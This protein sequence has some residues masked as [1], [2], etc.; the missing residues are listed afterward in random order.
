M[1][2]DTTIRLN[3]FFTP[4]LPE[5][6]LTESIEK[7]VK[8]KA[9]VD[10]RIHHFISK[11]SLTQWLPEKIEEQYLEEIKTL[12]LKDWDAG[13]DMSAVEIQSICD[14]L[15][16]GYGSGYLSEENLERIEQEIEGVEEKFNQ[17]VIQLYK[18]SN[19]HVF[20]NTMAKVQC[21]TENTLMISLEGLFKAAAKRN[22]FSLNL[23]EN[24]SDAL[25]RLSEKDRL[26]LLSFFHESCLLS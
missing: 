25:N 7:R 11:I 10:E 3:P 2:I 5:E 26:Y 18:Y 1:T 13:L 6:I 14:F 17:K 23:I 8:V 12:L 19:D 24:V 15:K 22:I 4:V 9:H 16:R 21:I 20:I